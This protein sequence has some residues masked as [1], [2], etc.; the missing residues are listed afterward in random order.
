MAL[1]VARTGEET[2]QLQ[3][4]SLDEL[5]PIDCRFRRIERL[6]S[7]SAVRASAEPFYTDFGRP[8]VDPVVLVKLVLVGAV[9]GIGSMR[10]VLRVAH[11]SLAIRR[12]LGY[13]LTEALPSHA[14]VSHA[15]TQRFAGSS[16]FEQLFTQVLA[17]CREHGLLDG[18]RLVV[19]ATHVE[20]DAALK[21][22]RAELQVIEG[23]GEQ[24]AADEDDDAPG[25]R[26]QLALAAPRSGPT[27]KRSASN[28]TVVS[29]TDP[30]AKLRHKPGQRPHLVHRVQVATDPK[31]R[32]IVAVQ[33]ERATGHEGDAL[34]ALIARARWAGHQV[35]EVCADQG[36]AGKDVYG[37][38]ER[39]GVVA[40]IPP[41][42]H[43][44]KKGVEAQAARA[45]CKTSAG[46]SA[47]IDRMTHGEGAIGEL[48]LQ[49][50]LGRARR[51]GTAALQLQALVAATA[52]NLKRL[53]SRPNL[54]QGGAAGRDRYCLR[55]WI[56]SLKRSTR[57]LIFLPASATATS[58]TAS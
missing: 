42:A 1:G 51:R 31:A 43:Q 14:T 6:V 29:R 27:P 25:G 23:E 54:A 50:G 48:K 30:D 45:R 55:R 18:R 3:M 2:R 19:D 40:F 13:G 5:V 17:Q 11:D 33:A 4:V 16:V 47:T 15:Q 49:H 58:L 52:I 35:S 57:W 36:Y 41:Q 10:R 20:A 7:W 9:E 26:P 46:I 37:R 39:L 12:F 32:V 8:S 22:L 53:L 24:R 38:L 56:L 28:A 21:S 34:P 44:A